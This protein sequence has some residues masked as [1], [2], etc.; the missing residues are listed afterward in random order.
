MKGFFKSPKKTAIL[1]LIASIIMLIT[2]L[3]TLYTSNII[4]N[5][6]NLYIIGLIVY[7]TIIL[8]RM[9]KQKGNIKTAN[10]LLLITYIISFI[11]VILV[12]IAEGDFLLIDIVLFGTIIVY[13]FNILFRK[14]KII[15]NKVFA[16]FL[17][18]FSAYQSIRFGIYFLDE[19]DLY[20]ILYSIKYLGY[21]AIVPYFYN[22]YE[23]LKEENRNG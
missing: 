19:K 11:G 7:F 16:I 18:G 8:M 21:M 3:T 15:N 9:R 13:L 10:T 20:L 22:Y 6:Y 17:I 12:D 2:T 23:L 1:G 14:L 4:L 5:S